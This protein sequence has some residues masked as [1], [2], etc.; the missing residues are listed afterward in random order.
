[1]DLN[2]YEMQIVRRAV[3]YYMR[4]VITDHSSVAVHNGSDCDSAGAVLLAEEQKVCEKLLEKLG[5]FVVEG[6]KDE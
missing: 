5:G 2:S 3:S 4:G 6:M 1:M